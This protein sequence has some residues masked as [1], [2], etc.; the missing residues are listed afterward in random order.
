MLRYYK[1]EI[2]EGIE[3]NKT[4]MSKKCTTYHY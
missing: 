4:N 2:V 3:V 1:V